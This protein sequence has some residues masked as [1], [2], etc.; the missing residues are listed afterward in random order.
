MWNKVERNTYSTSG[1][2]ATGGV[3][4]GWTVSVNLKRP[5]EYQLYKVGS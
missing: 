4:K 1:V 2:V 3:K 5:F